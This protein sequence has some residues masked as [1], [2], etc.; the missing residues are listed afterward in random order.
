MVEY[1]NYEDVRCDNGCDWWVF[2]LILW[3]WFWGDWWFDGMNLWMSLFDCVM[4]ILMVFGVC[5]ICGN[6]GCFLWCIVMVKWVIV[7]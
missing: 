1:E 2:F 3:W 6:V 5:V 4:L 7:C